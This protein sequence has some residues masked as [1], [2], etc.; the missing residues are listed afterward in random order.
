MFSPSSSFGSTN[1][2]G[3]SRKFI[4][5]LVEAINGEATAIGFYAEILTQVHGDQVAYDNVKHAYD[6]ERKHFR[7]FSRLYMKL[8]GQE[9]RVRPKRVAYGSLREAYRL[10]FFDELEAQELYNKMY[11]MAKDRK[12]RDIFY[13]AR[14]DE[15][16]HSQRFQYLYHR[17]ER[18]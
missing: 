17:E 14:N 10:A 18:K 7:Q 8:T 2:N 5:L 16:E 9:P 13:G 1:D 12:I 15:S 6:D 4:D 11:L 3:V